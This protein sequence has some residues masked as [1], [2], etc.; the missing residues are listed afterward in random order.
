[1][2]KLHAEKEMFFWRVWLVDCLQPVWLRLVRL[3]PRRANEQIQFQADQQPVCLHDVTFALREQTLT[4]F[5]RFHLLNPACLVH[6]FRSMDEKR[7]AV[8]QESV[9]RS[10][11]GCCELIVM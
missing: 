4:S 6:V 3:L 5:L 7:Y 11:A 1:M 10:T 9:F 8:S 2:Q